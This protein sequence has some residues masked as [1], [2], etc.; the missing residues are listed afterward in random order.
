MTASTGC[1]RTCHRARAE[2]SGAGRGDVC[3]GRGFR[4]RSSEGAGSDLGALLERG[5]TTNRERGV[6]DPCEEPTELRRGEDG[7]SKGGR[8]ITGK[9]G[10]NG[11]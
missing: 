1:D 2:D 8:A 11:Y 10:E 7:V 3:S 9:N 6:R 5:A 4:A